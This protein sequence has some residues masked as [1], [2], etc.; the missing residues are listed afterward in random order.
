M[1]I[2]FVEPNLLGVIDHYVT[3]APGHDV[4]VPMLVVAI[5]EGCYVMFTLFRSSQVSVDGF[6]QDICMVELDLN[7]LK[8]IMDGQ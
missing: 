1:S 5:G 4:Y 8:E 6:A 3:P 2:R 7:I